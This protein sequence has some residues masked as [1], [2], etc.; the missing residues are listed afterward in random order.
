MVNKVAGYPRK[1]RI[2][3]TRYGIYKNDVALGAAK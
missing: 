3:P 2:A 1:M